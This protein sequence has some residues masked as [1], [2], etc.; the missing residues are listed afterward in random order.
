MKNKLHRNYHDSADMDIIGHAFHCAHVS[1]FD[2]FIPMGFTASESI[3][4]F[5]TNEY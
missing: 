5:D 4:H 3:H 1:N 2:V